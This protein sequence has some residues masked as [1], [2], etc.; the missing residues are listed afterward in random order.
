MSELLKT[1]TE[2]GN[3]DQSYEYSVINATFDATSDYYP[4]G[5]SSSTDSHL[6]IARVN[7]NEPVAAVDTAYNNAY[8]NDYVQVNVK[9]ESFDEIAFSSELPVKPPLMPKPVSRIISGTGSLIHLN[10]DISPNGSNL[11]P[12]RTDLEKL[13]P[14]IEISLYG[15]EVLPETSLID[16][17]S[18][19]GTPSDKTPLAT[20]ECKG[21]VRSKLKSRYHIFSNKDHLFSH[22][23]HCF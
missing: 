17:D 16:S 6:A 15:S 18:P 22:I 11:R 7:V 20:L 10:P 3:F 23:C 19:T 21:R 13:P 4:P 9:R 1:S 14:Q 12:E 8:N 5:Q 2:E